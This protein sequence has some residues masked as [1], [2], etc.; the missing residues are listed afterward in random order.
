MPLSLRNPKPL[1]EETRPSHENQVKGTKTSDPKERRRVKFAANVRAFWRNYEKSPQDG[2]TKNEKTEQEREPTNV[3]MDASRSSTDQVAVKEDP[4]DEGSV[5]IEEEQDLFSAETAEEKITDK[6]LVLVSGYANEIPVQA[7]PDTGASS[8]YISRKA[9]ELAGWK[10]PVGRL[11][12]VRVANGKTIP[13]HG[14]FNMKLRLP[15]SSRRNDFEEYADFYVVDMEPFNVILGIEFWRKYLCRNDYKDGG[16][17]LWKRGHWHHIPPEKA[18]MTPALYA[19]VLEADPQPAGNIPQIAW[20][21][22]KQMLELEERTNGKRKGYVQGHLWVITDPETLEH[23]LNQTLDGPGNLPSFLEKELR[24]IAEEFKDVL[25]SEL[26]QGTDGKHSHT[27]HTID[28]GDAKPVNLPFYR[29]SPIHLDEQ[30]KQTQELLDKGLIRPSVSPWG[31]PVLFVQKSDKTWRMCID[32]RALNDVTVKNKFPLPR[33][34]EQIDQTGD[35]AIFSKIDLL[36]GFWQIKMAESSVEKTAFNTRNGKY[37]FLVM[38]FGLTN[39]PPT[40][41]AAMNSLLRPFLDK[42]VVVYI[43]DLLIYSKTEEEHVQHVRQVMEKLRE[44]G[45]FA[46][47]SKCTFGVR[48]IEFCGHVIGGGKVRM[49]KTKVDAIKDWPRPKTVHHVRQFLGLCSYYRRFIKDFARLASPMHDLLKTEGVHKHRGIIWNAGCESSFLKLKD[50]VISEP[51]LAQPDVRAPFIIETDA[52]DFAR[53]A[54]LLQVGKD[55]K[56]HPVAFESKKFTGAERNYPTHERELLAI[57]DALRAWSFYI[58]NGHRTIIRTDHAGLQ[59]M[60]TTRVQSKRLARWIMEFGSFDLDIRYKPGSQMTVPDALSRRPDFQE[61]AEALNVLSLELAAIDLVEWMQPYLTDG[62][63]PETTTDA[64]YVKSRASEFRMEPTVEDDVELQHQDP[65]DESAP[66]TTVLPYWARQ[67]T[68]ESAHKSYG[69]AGEL[70]MFDIFRDRYWWPT[71]KKDIRDM[72]RCCKEC[73]LAGRRHEKRHIAPQVPAT[74]WKNRA[75][76]AFD[77]WGLDLIGTL[78]KTGS[79]NRHII[80]AIDYATKWPVAKAVPDATAE[81]LAEFLYELYLNYGVPKEIITDQGRNLWAPAVEIFLKKIGTKHSGTT[82]YHPRTNGAVERLNGVLVQCLTKYLA[83]QTVRKWDLYLDAALFAA[84]IRTHDTTRQSP[85][86]M[87]YGRKPRLP[88]DNNEWTPS[89]AEAI[90]DRLPQFETARREARRLEDERAEKN[91]RQWFKDNEKALVGVD[92]FKE[93]EHVL[94]RNEAKEKFDLN[95]YGP[96]EVKEVGP[97]NTYK[98]RTIAGKDGKKGEP[99]PRMV[100]GDRLHR[101]KIQGKIT[102]SWNLPKSQSKK[103]RTYGSALDQEDEI[104]VPVGIFEPLPMPQDDPT[105]LS[106]ENP[107]DD[108]R[109]D[110]PLRDPTEPEVTLD[111][112]MDPDAPEDPNTIIVDATDYPMDDAEEESTGG[113]DEDMAAEPQI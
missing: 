92:K 84:R 36:S 108:P 7:L 80:V 86:F 109:E 27:Q 65:T 85:F 2:E 64:A 90:T 105:T 9:A 74:E 45:F 32:Y 12:N 48:E 3:E 46:K 95:W 31:A 6:K 88:G 11:G 112:L 30:A 28:T 8:R 76:D 16:I 10:T 35:A 104:R 44:A 113:H 102:R 77:R 87:L 67:D 50:A 21:K 59:Y 56:E 83:G 19:H 20:R 101:A 69:H 17:Q 39:A 103:R 71:M 82:A 62:T 40:F 107:A 72:C 18:Y 1:L 43:D 98:L 53:G 68:M 14:K 49:T 99:L 60:K 5:T 91:K 70:T 97:H 29:L 42:F 34:Q 58:D 94:V 111:D 100:S 73:Q 51:V 61:S 25:R 75:Y 23:S 47:P 37:E 89:N 38:P 63:L 22:A 33:I 15:G 13:I 52:S 93:G 106:N 41:Q 96:Y 66:W 110:F 57:K 4:T 26:P 54:Q 24:K 79:G 81:T 55:G 78:K